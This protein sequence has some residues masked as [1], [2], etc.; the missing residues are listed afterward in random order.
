MK[1]REAVCA[2]GEAFVFEVRRGRPP[3]SCQKCR[4]VPKAYPPP[5]KEKLTAQERV[6][7]LEMML[8]S[9]GKH[10]GQQPEKP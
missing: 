3:K 4:L 6:D 5:V 9:E 8:K 2:C 10:I 7:R 1:T